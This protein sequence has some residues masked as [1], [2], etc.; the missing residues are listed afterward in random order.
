MTGIPVGDRILTPGCSMVVRDEEL[1]FLTP[2]VR[3]GRLR[4]VRQKRTGHWIAHYPTVERPEPQEALTNGHAREVRVHAWTRE[5]LEALSTPELRRIAR[6]FHIQPGHS[7]VDAIQ[8]IL[9]T[10]ED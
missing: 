10:E 1:G 9:G 3:S 6:E 7:K 4:L 2:F 5:A 8:A